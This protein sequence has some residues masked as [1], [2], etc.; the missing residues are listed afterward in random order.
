MYP[1]V[2]ARTTPDRPA[3]VMAETGEAVTYK[4]LDERSARLARL[5]QERGLRRGDHVAIVLENHPRF[6]D[7]VWAALRSGLYYT[8]VNWHLTAEEVAYITAD[9]G[10]RSVVT[11]AIRGAQVELVDVEVP[12]V[13]DGD[14]DGW[15]RYERATAEM[16]GTPLDDEPEGA[17]MFYSSGT[18]GRPKGIVFPLPD[19]SVRDGTNLRVDPRLAY[20]PDD[21]YLSPAPLYHAAPVVSCSL[22]HRAGGTALVLERWDAE[23]CLAAIDR[24]RC[25]HAQFVPTMF[26]RL[27]KLPEDVRRRYD[28]SSLR[29]VTHA[30]APCPI[31]VKQAMIAWL[32]PIL[33][34]YYSRSENIGTTIIGPEEWLAHPGSVGRPTRSTVH[35]CDDRG[36]ELSA[37]ETGVIWFDTPG[38][39]FEYHGDPG[40]TAAATSPQGWHTLGDIGHVDSDGYLYLTD[41]QAFTIVSGG[42]NIYPQEAENVLVLHPAVADAA[43]IGVPNDDL[44]EEVKAVVELVDAAAAGADLAADLIAFCRDRLA[45]FKCPQSVD[46][47]ALPRDDNGKLYKRL[48]KDRY[49]AGRSSGIV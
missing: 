23:G 18:T 9:C 32:G 15:E 24:Y 34:E 16:S 8:P 37:G 38:A 13:V 48:L 44:G 6:F 10:A 29:R 45:L 1:G 27:L 40:K 19:G 2:H 20:S 22:V 46:F 26:V 4:M 25:T 39:R 49:W 5:W 7:A 3:I 21:T 35:V 14:L 30:A 43:V 28:L 17:G 33:W 42:V 12:L 11:S 47:G 31:D 41:R 36:R